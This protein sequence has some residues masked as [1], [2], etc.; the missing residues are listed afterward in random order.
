MIAY[1]ESL[2]SEPKIGISKFES[3]LKPL[4]LT[5]ATPEE[6]RKGFLEFSQVRN[7]IVHKNSNVDKAF[8]DMCPWIQTVLGGKLSVSQEDFKFYSIL[9]DWYYIELS[10]R[11]NSRQE[12]E[13]EKEYIEVQQMLFERIIQ[14]RSRWAEN[15]E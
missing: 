13:P 10:M 12:S 8:Q 11:I 7:L 2:K 6:I 15:A 3:L 5:S 4:G 1:K 9:V 14:S